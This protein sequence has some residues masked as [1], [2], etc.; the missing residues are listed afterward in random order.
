MLAV[1]TAAAAAGTSV[2]SAKVPV[3]VAAE[4]QR[5]KCA[6]CGTE[7]GMVDTWR[8]AA[9][10]DEKWAAP[11]ATVSI[12]VR[13]GAELRKFLAGRGIAHTTAIENVE[14]L[15]A[16]E[17]MRVA[18]ARSAKDAF[19][20]EYR[21]YEE[22]MAKL[23]EFI[24]TYS[25]V[26]GF[27]VGNSVEGR[28]Q[29][30]I[31]FG[32]SPNKDAVYLQC[33]IHAREWISPATCMY[34]TEKLLSGMKSGDAEATAL[35][36]SLIIYLVPVAN[37]DGYSFTFT[38]NRLWRKNRRANSDGSFGVDLN[39]N[40]DDG[41][42]GVCGASTS[43]RSDTYMGTAAFSE[44]ETANVRA[45]FTQLEGEGVHLQ[46]GIDFHSYG[47]LLLRPYGWNLPN[48][49]CVDGSGDGKTC[50]PPNDA[51]NL[52]AMTAYYDGLQ[53]SGVTSGKWT[54]EH[55]AE[56][57][58]AAGGTD[59][60]IAVKTRQASGFCVELRPV[61]LPGFTLPASGIVPSGEENYAAI[62]KWGAHVAKNIEVRK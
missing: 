53:S 2:F 22:I 10:F 16:A 8:P 28:A 25:G 19:F 21:T 3:S 47:Q 40:W 41:H 51:E 42:W 43:P 37:P 24:N 60:W 44:P 46:S 30:G 15:I 38:D 4:M 32:S 56:L 11:N 13:G 27:S 18:S 36:S 52:A 7:D 57:Y 9:V 55:A 61:G 48:R 1:L 33:G 59:D 58:C 35:L 50:T 14:E 34:F 54:S 31:K 5:V 20:E 49:G 6:A 39:R 45:F 62:L 29:R 17:R 26:E 12:D 23:D